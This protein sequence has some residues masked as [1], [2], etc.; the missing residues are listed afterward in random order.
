MQAPGKDGKPNPDAPYARTVTTAI[1]GDRLDEF[2]EAT[3]AKG[4]AAQTT[5]EEKAKLP[6][7]VAKENRVNAATEA[8]EE[9]KAH[10]KDDQPIVAYDPGND[11]NVVM[12]KGDLPQGWFSYPLKDPAQVASTVAG[13]NDVQTKINSLAQF[14]KGGGMDHIQPGLVGDAI[15]EAD[16][17][18]KVGA[19][20]AALPTARINA[21]LDQENYKAMNQASRDFVRNYGFAREAITQLPRLQTFGKSNRMN[22]TQMKAALQLLPDHRMDSKAARD[23]M[24]ALQQIL[25]PLR[26][27]LPE[28]PGAKLTPSFTEQ[29][30]Q[31]Q[32]TQPAAQQTS[33]PFA[34]FGGKAR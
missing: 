4:K 32:T 3:A 9:R 19:F 15:A 34:A 2:D 7:E 14:I 24:Q 22:D 18:L 10:A 11:K 30:A 31:Q 12:T 25:D 20:G 28:M 5:A 1:G 33:D 6:F 13:F 16:K 17:E 8:R 23:Q 29:E 21:I 26:K 27:S